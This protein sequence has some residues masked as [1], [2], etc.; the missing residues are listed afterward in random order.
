MK[1]IFG[2]VQLML[3]YG[4]IALSFFQEGLNITNT[5]LLIVLLVI[6]IICILISVY[7]YKKYGNNKLALWDIIELIVFII[8]SLLDTYGIIEFETYFTINLVVDGIDFW[9]EEKLVGKTEER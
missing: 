4:F 8:T 5:Y 1:K 9:L 3:I 7:E 6:S 2:L